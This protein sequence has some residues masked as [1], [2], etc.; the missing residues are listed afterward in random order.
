MTTSDDMVD[1][2]QA[3]KPDLDVWRA[4]AGAA[5][6]TPF[7]GYSEAARTGWPRDA[8]RV[9]ALCDRVAALEG[10]LNKLESA[11]DVIEGEG[12]CDDEDNEEMRAHVAELRAVVAPVTAR[13]SK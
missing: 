11:V 7:L 12:C 2:G 13:A 4:E 6:A 8:A 1:P 10:A 3:G 9:A 5:L